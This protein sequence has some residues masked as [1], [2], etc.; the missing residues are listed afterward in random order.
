MAGL[1]VRARTVDMLGRQQIAGIP[2]AIHELFKNAHDAYARRVEV[3]YHRKQRVLILRDDGLGMTREEV[4]SRWLTL[5]T[6]CKLKVNASIGDVWTGPEGLESRVVMGEKGI[7]RLAVAVIAPITLML[8]R[9][10]RPDGHDDLVAV[11]VHW[12]VFEQPGIDLDEVLIPIHE[13]P[14]GSLPDRVALGRMIGELREN[15]RGLSGQ[16]PTGAVDT[17]FASLDTAAR[18]DPSKLDVT[19]NNHR[20]KP[21][22][23]SGDGHGTWFF[24]LPVA[25]ELDLDIDHRSDGGKSGDGIESKLQQILLGFANSMDREHRQVLVT[26]F[27]D[28]GLDGEVVEL[29]G[30]KNFFDHSAFTLTDHLI[31]GAFDE[32]GQFHGSIRFYQNEPREMT[33]S[34]T[35]GKGRPI[36]CGPFKFRLGVLMGELGESA[37][38]ATDH[39]V[40]RQRLNAL[41]GLYVYRDGIR[42]L[43]YGTWDHDFL[44]IEHRRTLAA[45][46]WFYSYRRMIG[47]VDLRHD[48][49]HAL[50]EK[51][52]REGFRENL[53]FRDFRE[54]LVNLFR[55]TAI[56]FFREGSNEGDEFREKRTLL[57]EGH[58]QLQ[59]RKRRADERRKEFIQ[60]L[61]A[62]RKEAEGG[63]FHQRARTLHDHFTARLKVVSE[64]SDSGEFL[65]ALFALEREFLAGIGAFNRDLTL[66]KPARLALGRQE[67]EWEV[68]QRL[69]PGIRADTVGML[70]QGIGEAISRLARDRVDT[71]QRRIVAL[72][73][74]G[75]GRESVRKEAMQYRRKTE[76]TA[77]AFRTELKKLMNRETRGI[78]QD[79][80]NLIAD[81]TRD[82]VVHPDR[83][84]TRLM[85]V[86]KRLVEMRDGHVKVLNDIRG[87]LEE[88]TESIRTGRAMDHGA[89][90]LGNRLAQLEDQREFEAQFVQIGMT[91][92][93]LGH[94]FERAAAG[95]RSGM[96]D[97]KPWADKTPGL[98][99][100]YKR[101]RESFEYL[102]GYLMLLDPLGRRMTRRSVEVPGSDIH[103]YLRRIFGTQLEGTGVALQTTS[104]F[105][106]QRIRCRSSSLLGAMT[107]LVDNAI[108]WVQRSVTGV[109][110]ITLDADDH[111]FLVRNTGPG[112]SRFDAPH[113]FDFG[114]SSRP[115]GRGMGL[116]VSRQALLG[117]DLSLELITIGEAVEPVFRIAPLGN[118]QDGDDQGG[119]A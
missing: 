9:A 64:L 71:D 17:L 97:L 19:L 49:N 31:E 53:A 92:G 96:R 2:T 14:G 58:A 20:E 114:W 4:E 107:N 8:T 99:S 74:L 22:T 27:R 79:L 38:N 6:E 12:G 3:D 46:D 7:G 70:E 59:A 1:R 34:W 16:L 80:E 103:R 32:Y 65:D 10:I 69:M 76:R 56:R 47:Y 117:E 102:D 86:E 48:H 37:L 13:F 98:M 88:I 82:T 119:G 42:V 93:I 28:H 39:A 63:G 11:L 44:G 43:P 29:I 26:E 66:I 73:M 105:E 75:S 118:D 113:I 115:G 90:V 91:V 18:I 77:E 23:L 25:P 15:I 81:F 87:Q 5:G 85:E 109:K 84:E 52:G 51:A 95:L 72:N 21:L 60:A 89:D 94:E 104:A 41:G 68:H 57:E 24:C 30:G 50:N 78:S 100:V 40:M 116:S 54:V 36:R 45:K 33:C 35:G 83:I 110:V 55:E 67:K 61:R 111:G 106:A 112:I 101:L 62:F 108:Y